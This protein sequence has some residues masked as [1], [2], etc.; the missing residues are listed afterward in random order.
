MGR[1]DEMEVRVHG[2]GRD[3][4]DMA[5]SSSSSTA[6]AGRGKR[7]EG[8]GPKDTADEGRFG[9]LR[10][11]MSLVRGVGIP[12]AQWTGAVTGV[13]LSA[14]ESG[15]VDAVVCIA[16]GSGE[17][18]GGEVGSSWSEPKPIVARTAEEVMRGRGVKPALAP[19]LAVLDE[20]REDES[21]R[22]LL[23]CGV[24]CAVQGEDGSADT[25]G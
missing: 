24:G 3:G 9:V 6:A 4:A 19:S 21:I 20:I 7:D 10:R 22:R 14:L 15:M 23:F 17:G 16:S 25:D 13:A 2:R 8:V 18:G 1:V 5:W 11:P 12:G